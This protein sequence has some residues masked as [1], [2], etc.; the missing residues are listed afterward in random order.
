MIF[1]IGL[2]HV[3]RLPRLNSLKCQVPETFDLAFKLK[4]KKFTI[5]V[6]LLLR[7]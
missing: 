7:Q 4:R 3:L 1:L 6:Y 2:F 5:E